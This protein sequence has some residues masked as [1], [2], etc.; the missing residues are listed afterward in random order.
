RFCFFFFFSSRRRHTRFSRDWSS[1]VC[2]SD[3]AGIHGWGGRRGPGAREPECQPGTV[4]D[5]RGAG[6]VA[7][8]RL[9]GDS[10]ATRRA[11][12]SA[13][14][15]GGHMGWWRGGGCHRRDD[16]ALNTP[17]VIF[18][19]AESP[20]LRYKGTLTVLASRG[21]VPICCGSGHQEDNNKE[22]TWMHI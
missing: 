6:R 22:W 12:L 8:C 21:R 9:P 7:L 20:C 16:P 14:G 19:V 4:D 13:S 1:D 11:D 10:H 17:V 5:R 2:S 15:R 18:N 3:L